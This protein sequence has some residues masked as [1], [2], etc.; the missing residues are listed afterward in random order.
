MV[1]DRSGPPHYLNVYNPQPPVEVGD[2]PYGDYFRTLSPGARRPRNQW[3]RWKYL[4][5]C[6]NIAEAYWSARERARLSWESSARELIE[7]PPVVLWLPYTAHGACLGC[8]WIDQEG[9]GSIEEA[10]VSA[11][12]HS[13]ERGADPDVIAGLRV[14]ISERNGP[15][16]TPLR[17]MGAWDA[18]PAS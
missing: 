3:S 13:T 9:S 10:A 18:P 7:H 11:R 17:S 12:R 5:T 6:M 2:A 4:S 8:T 16:D 1:R 14:P 15:H